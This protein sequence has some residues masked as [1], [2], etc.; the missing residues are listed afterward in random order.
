MDFK[1]VFDGDLR[2]HQQIGLKEI[3]QIRRELAPQI[4]AAW[5]YPPLSDV[6]HW[7]DE[8][9]DAAQLTCRMTI[10][11]VLFIPMISAKTSLFAEIDV[12]LLRAQAPGR[13]IS[14]HGDIDNRLKTLLDAL[15]VPSKDQVQKLKACNAFD[16]EPQYCLLEDDNLVTKLS[17]S[18]DRLLGEP[19]GSQRTLAVLSIRAKPSRVVW[20]NLGF[21]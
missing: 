15:R 13:L 2:P 6:L 11:G 8:Q 5:S 14:N 1:L 21:T 4:R 10:D 17:V 19:H 18:T 3:N 20:D 7:K 12:L 16:D 9:R